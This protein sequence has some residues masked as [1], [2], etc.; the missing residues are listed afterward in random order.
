MRTR[1]LVVW[2][3]ILLPVSLLA[4]GLNPA[5]VHSYGAS[6]L[7]GASVEHASAIFPGDLVQT[8][9]G[10]ILKIDASGSTVT[11][12]SDSLVKFEGDAAAVEHGSAQLSTS[13]SMSA[14]A[15]SVTVTPL[16]S[17]LT[18]YQVIRSNGSVQVVALK[19]DV[20][21]SNGSQTATLAQGQQATQ[22]SSL[23]S[24][25]A[26]QG[27]ETAMSRQKPP[28]FSI[29]STKA[30][31]VEPDVRAV[32]ESSTKKGKGSPKLP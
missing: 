21:I 6:W 3:L 7:N 15:G 12:L 23:D 25:A 30:S 17:A 13:T 28:A 16:S 31:G 10:A 32:G 29:T 2:T 8:N 11:V 9:P 14:R 19:G 22:T 5:M 27:M 26:A 24:R 20:R 1:I 4:A 18:E